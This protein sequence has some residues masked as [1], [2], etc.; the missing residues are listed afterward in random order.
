MVTFWRGGSLV[1]S[2]R[3]AMSTRTQRWLR[4]LELIALLFAPFSGPGV[5]AAATAPASAGTPRPAPSVPSPAV[6]GVSITVSDGQTAAKAGDRLTYVVNVRDSGP[7]GAPHLKITQSLSAGLEFISASPHGVATAGQVAWPASI[8][9]GRSETFKVVARGTRTPAPETAAGGCRLRGAGRQPKADRL[10]GPPRP[11][12]RRRNRAGDLGWQ[13]PT[14]GSLLLY[15]AGPW[16]PWPCSWRGWSLAGGFACRRQ[17]GLTESWMGRA[18]SA[19]PRAPLRGDGG[20]RLQT[21]FSPRPHHR[22]A[23]IAAVYAGALIGLTPARSS[24]LTRIVI[25]VT[26]NASRAIPAETRNP[27]EKPTAR[28]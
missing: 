16:R 5:T 28:A 23:V 12:V 19:A 26:T 13:P 3:R 18:G 14:S 10:R 2:S 21:T 15:M 17:P 24:R 7:A 1:R 11:V 22:A 27:R 8:P 6:P 4:R 20:R 9:A 25:T